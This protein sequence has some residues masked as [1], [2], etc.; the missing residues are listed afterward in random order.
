MTRL[1]KILL[2]LVGLTA[3]GW[4]VAQ[5]NFH[6]IGRTIAQLGWRAPLLLLP[7]LAVSI[8]DC[9]GWWFS[10]PDVPPISFLRL[11][12]IRWAGEAVNQV[13]PS[14][15]LGG[16]A[17]KI[18]LLSRHQVPVRVSAP[19][20]M[21]SKT[22]QTCAQLVFVALASL[23]YLSLGTTPLAF[24]RAMLVV[25]VL[26]SAIVLL[27]FWVQ[28]RGMFR[29]FFNVLARCRLRLAVFERRREALLELDA[30]I[31]RCFS[32]SRR[33]LFAA[34]TG[35]LIGWLLDAAEIWFAAWLV[36]APL[37]WAQAVAIEGFVGVVRFLG[38]AVPGAIGVQESGLLLLCRMAA[39]P[40]SFAVLYAVLRRAR[41]AAFVLLGW[42]WLLLEGAG[43]QGLGARVRDVVP[44]PR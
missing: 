17:A 37:T 2:L 12:R 8:A 10:F 4:F 20:A 27:M 26:G 23:A 18:Y 30:W 33:R 31:G 16:E 39:V 42:Q 5:V 28:R 24:Q 13:V 7:Y 3:L 14:A 22:V 19:V 34:F 40:E 41:E 32:V 43:M 6:E 35:Y 36:Q 11:L 15:Y 9:A 25:F 21:L 1:V 29:L 38:L 44:G